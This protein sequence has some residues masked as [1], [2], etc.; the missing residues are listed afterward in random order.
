MNIDGRAI[1]EDIYIELAQRRTRVAGTVSLG[2]VVASHDP[3]IESFVRIKSRAARRLNIELRR[4]DLLN[5]PQTADALAA[6]EQLGPKVNGIIV[7]LPL[8]EALDTEGILSAIPPF[9]DVDGINPTVV[10]QG[11][12][13][14]APVAGAIEEILKRSNIEVHGK[15]CVVVGAG[16]LVGAP[17]AYFMRRLGA[18]VSVVTLE[19]GS[20]DEL[21][22]A[23]IVILGAG[24][25]GFVKPDMIKE[26]VILIDAGTSEQ[27]GKVRGDADPACAEKASLFTPVPGGLGP[28]AVAMIFKNLFDLTEK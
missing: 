13:V 11:R 10:D 18:L 21:K 12:A 6:I 28:I 5:Q 20:L 2:I 3:V 23:D 16:K 17:A 7:Q 24:N 27:G 1:A 15:K 19:S 26:G 9:L 8:P 14:L 4:L 25:P 22:S